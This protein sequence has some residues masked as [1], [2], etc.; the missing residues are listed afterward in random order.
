VFSTTDRRFITPY[1]LL[2]NHPESRSNVL[3][4]H[5]HTIPTFIPLSILA[6]K[7]LPQPLPA[8]SAPQD[9]PQNLPGLVR[10]LRRELVAHHKRLAAWEL[11][12]R[13]VK[14]NKMLDA[15]G[16]RFEIELSDNSIARL[17]VDMHGKIENAIVRTREGTNQD[18]VPDNLGRRQR[19]I[20]RAILGGGGRVEGL[21]ERIK[22]HVN[23]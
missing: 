11:L 2:L 4:I 22:E 15:A 1:Y 21:I 18:E 13:G 10:A 9:Q 23:T 19:N 5:K 6:K 12:Q 7:Y 20:E 8:N 14:T 17:T 3:R 16:T